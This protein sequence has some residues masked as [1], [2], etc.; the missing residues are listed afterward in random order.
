MQIVLLGTGTPVLD[1]AREHSA[2][3]I[4]VAGESLLFD[5]GRGVTSNMAR[6][7]DLPQK[8]GAIFITHHHFDHIGGLGELLMTAWHNGR[9][10]PLDV[11]GPPGTA[12]IIDALLGTVFARDIAFALAADPGTPHIRDVVRVTEIGPG[13]DDNRGGWRVS[14]A[15]V[16][17]GHALGISQADFPCL[18]YRLECEGRVIAI[19]GDTVDCPGLDQIARDADVLVQCCYLAE[20]EITTPAFERMARDVIASSRQAG[21]IAARNRVGR[22]VLTHF[23]PKSPELMKSILGDIRREY[24]GEAILG[25][26]LMVLEI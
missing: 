13:W 5:A 9:V 20:A 15:Q 21:R 12:A 22:L 17:H 24:D 1:A 8:L 11:F 4:R 16:E 3:L 19:S 2:L 7:G 6:L 10:T 23:R 18:G 26:D 14:S 25:E